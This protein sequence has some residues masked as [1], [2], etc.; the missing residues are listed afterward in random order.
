MAG[1]GVYYKRNLEGTI[2][3]YLSINEI[4]AITGVR[5]CGK[6]T[7][8][9]KIA[10]DIEPTKKVNFISFD[11]ISIL[12]LFEQ[13]IDTFVEAHVKPYDY[14]FIDEIQYS[15]ESGKKLKYIYDHFSIKLI[16]SGSSAAEIAVQGIKYLVGRIFTFTLYPFSFREFIQI[17]DKNLLPVYDKGGYKL[18][19]I[20]KLNQYLHEFLLY[21]GFPR[22]LIASNTQEKTAILKNIYNTYLLR[23]IRE[24]FQVADN[25]KVV[26]LI[27]LLGLQIGNLVNLNEL[28]NQSGIKMGELKNILNILESTFIIAKA[29]PYFTNKRKE[30]V[31]SPKVYFIDPGFRNACLENFSETAL[32]GG[33]NMEQF[34]FSEFQKQDIALKY[35]RSKSQAEVDFIFEKEGN[36]FP[37]EI[38]TSLRGVKLSRSF[39]SFL[40]KYA[41]QTGYVLSETFEEGY[42]YK[43][44]QSIQFLPWVKSNKIYSQV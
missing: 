27:K 26:R 21:G 35:W 7:L 5:Q 25:L 34:I 2:K 32:S 44:K 41:C 30:L 22:V 42:H 36:V 3:A 12:Q 1:L 14:L 20:K 23:E 16:I 10:S 4:I 31:K 13:D 24:T 28:S 37:I 15:L 33:E 29:H 6:T 38:K 39:Q 19:T 11:D 9:K 43:N 18:P 17:K 40:G 8:M